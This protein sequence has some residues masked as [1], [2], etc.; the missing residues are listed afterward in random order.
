MK[1]GASSACIDLLFAASK[2][3][4]VASPWHEGNTVLVL[5]RLP[6]AQNT[7][8]AVPPPDG[9]LP[10]L[11]I[12]LLANAI[13]RHCENLIRRLLFRCTALQCDGLVLMIIFTTGQV[14]L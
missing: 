9:Q 12:G 2:E 8:C 4:T 13:Y 7:A 3:L 5:F 1:P 6:P 11:L 10:L 14:F